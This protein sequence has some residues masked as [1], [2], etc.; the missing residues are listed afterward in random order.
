MHYYEKQGEYAKAEDQLFQ[1]CETSAG[2]EGLSF[3]SLLGEG[4]YKRL[5]ALPD[6]IVS[7][8]GLPRDEVEFGRDEFRKRV[9]F[10]EA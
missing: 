8:G 6:S 5:S 4:F 9:T 1:L 3:L 10:R 7:G 2:G